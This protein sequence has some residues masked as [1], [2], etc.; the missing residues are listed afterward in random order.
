M[1]VADMANY[2]PVSNL[3]FLSKTIDRIVVEQ[4]NRY[5][6][7]NCY[8]DFSQHTGVSIPL[9]LLHHV[10]GTV[11]PMLLSCIYCLSRSHFFRQMSIYSPYIFHCCLSQCAGKNNWCVMMT[12][13]IPTHTHTVMSD[14]NMT[15][16][17]AS[18][19]LA[20]WQVGTYGRWR[21]VELI[22]KDRQLWVDDIPIAVLTIA[23]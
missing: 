8:R 2:R 1:D 7:A 13:R 17:T 22:G 6:T 19:R 20:E 3:S 11:C 16:Y 9:L 12:H 18:R 14:S 5:L 10:S 4:L 21:C 15:A 23:K